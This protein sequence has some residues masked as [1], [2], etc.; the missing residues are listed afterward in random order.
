MSGPSLRR[1]WLAS[2]G[3]AAGEVRPA[4]KYY[5]HGCALLR[6][7]AS[8]DEAILSGSLTRLRPVLMSALVA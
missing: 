5:P 3:I 6:E 2:G 7:G 1:F 4:V 8:I